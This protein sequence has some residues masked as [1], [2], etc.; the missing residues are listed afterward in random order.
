MN[1]SVSVQVEDSVSKNRA[2]LA[3]E[4]EVLENWV[5]QQSSPFTQTSFGVWYSIAQS[6]AAQIFIDATSTP[7][8]YLNMLRLDGTPYYEPTRIDNPLTN[9]SVPSGILKVMKEIPIGT[10]ATLAMPSALA[11]GATGDGQ[12]IPPNTPLVA[13]IFITLNTQKNNP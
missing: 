2:Q 11:F 1:Q 8:L 5:A 3:N 10:E 4:T 13:R 9:Q 6:D 7:I 12:L